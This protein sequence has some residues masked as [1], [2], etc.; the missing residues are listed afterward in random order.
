VRLL[1]KFVRDLFRTSD[2]GADTVT[3]SSAGRTASRTGTCAE[4]LQSADEAAR[5]GRLQT[6]LE[7]YRDCMQM[8]PNSL[9][10]CLGA[11]SVLVD[12]WSMDE[13]VA[14]Y[15]KARQLAPG[16]SAI[17]AALL[18]HCHYLAPADSRH[19]FELHRRYG[20]MLHAASPPSDERHLNERTADRKLRI[21]YVSPNLSRHSVGYFIEP[22]IRSHDRSRYQIVCYYNHA[23]ADDATRRM[24]ASADGWRDIAAADDDT[25][26]RWVREDR[27]DILID[28]AGHSKGNR[29]GLFARRAAPLQ[30]TWLGYPDT[31]GLAAVGYRITDAT[32]DPAPAADQLN[33][34]T[35]LR[36]DDCFLSYEPPADAPPVAARDAGERVVV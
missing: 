23:L 11:A 29:L 4:R 32:V 18:F 17:F 19:L 7:L 1:V 5:Q 3:E 12:L 34:E 13:A 2:D 6:A 9:D 14:A 33:T 25:V 20:A 10:A 24:R 35:L 21:G 27:I 16:S 30:M 8:Y 31:T 26:L 28:L 15:E 22:V 36:L